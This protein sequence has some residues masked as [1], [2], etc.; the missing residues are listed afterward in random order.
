MM[1]NSLFFLC[2]FIGV[3][4]FSC[5]GGPAKNPSEMRE[6]QPDSLK[7][8]RQWEKESQMDSIYTSLLKQKEYAKAIR[9]LEEMERTRNGR[10]NTPF[11]LLAK[12]NIYYA[13]HAY[14]S[15]RHYYQ[16]ATASID[17]QIATEA[18]H[19]LSLVDAAEGNMEKAYLNYAAYLD[20]IKW[21]ITA[22]EGRILH[23]RYQE[24]RLQNE[25]NE[26]RLAKQNREIWVLTLGSVLLI[27][28]AI[29]YF[30]FLHSKKRRQEAK[31]KLETERLNHENQLLKQHE[32]IHA[33]R[34]KEALLRESL[35]RRMRVTR[36]IP[37][38]EEN[39]TSAPTHQKIVLTDSD[40]K[41]IRQTV[42]ASYSHFTGRLESTYPGL[43]EKDLN[44]CCLL[45]INVSLQDLSDIYCI[46][47]TGVSKRK[48]R[49]KKEK[50]HLDN[51]EESL[52]E[53]L[54]RF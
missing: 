10:F 20:L 26:I 45:K 6:Q 40:W 21:E 11:Y 51:S 8:R 37:S 31:L 36:K 5:K 29:L 3:F 32:E 24:E 35:F 39:R 25:L 38:L 41:E 48:F 46:S 44:F 15:A 7:E 43:S 33:L 23:A 27:M 18:Y 1:K 50:F 13:T 30:F 49:L 53:F 34:G 47:K 19:R 16:L 22:E 54:Q 14:D 2:F 12:G 17:T 28:V 4:S 9:F 42:D 52:D